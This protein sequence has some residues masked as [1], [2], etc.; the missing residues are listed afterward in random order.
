MDCKERQRPSNSLEGNL[1]GCGQLVNSGPV[2]GKAEGTLHHPS[3]RQGGNDSPGEVLSSMESALAH[4]TETHAIK[5]THSGSVFI[6]NEYVLPELRLK[7]KEYL[8]CIIL[9]TEH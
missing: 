5:K 8:Q 3:T 6:E 9:N 7:F 4:H 1:P 2:S